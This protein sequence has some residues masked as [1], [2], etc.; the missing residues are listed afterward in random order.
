MK[1][2]KV[3][4]I[5][6]LIATTSLF[7]TE[8]VPDI[9]AKDIR[10][11]VADLLNSPDFSLDESVTVNVMFTFSSE[12]DI[13]L[14]KVDSTDQNIVKYISKNLNHKMIATP[15]EVN[16]VFTLPLRINKL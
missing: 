13:V 14:L 4:P 2:L 6:L 11:Q 12:G 10:V 15:G 7:A 5:A 8:I 16:R 3:L 9:P 1:N